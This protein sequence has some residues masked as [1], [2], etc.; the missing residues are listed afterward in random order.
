MVSSSSIRT[1]IPVP[2]STTVFVEGVSSAGGALVDEAK[3]EV[4][5]SSKLIELKSEPELVAPELVA[6]ES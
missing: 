5:I 6:P 3:V 1:Q 2:L 4:K